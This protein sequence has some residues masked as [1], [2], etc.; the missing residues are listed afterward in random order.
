MEC[1]IRSPDYLPTTLTERHRCY[2]KECTEYEQC[3]LDAEWGNA[4]PGAT[5]CTSPTI[6][7]LLD[8]LRKLNRW[9]ESA[10]LPLHHGNRRKPRFS[11]QVKH[12]VAR[13]VGRSRVPLDLRHC[14][15]SF[16]LRHV[17]LNITCLQAAH[18]PGTLSKTCDGGSAE[19]LVEQQSH[20]EPVIQGGRPMV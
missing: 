7:G 16:L 10:P 6:G 18:R 14:R 11:A 15:A 1:L 9:R 5:L 20:A 13:C 8:H 17:A 2:R 4:R 3:S 19:I 12:C